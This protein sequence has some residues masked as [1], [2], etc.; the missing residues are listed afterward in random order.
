LLLASAADYTP[1][2]TSPALIQ[3][4]LT[5]PTGKPPVKLTMTFSE[6]VNLGELDVSFIALVDSHGNQY[7]LTS[8]IATQNPFTPT[9]VEL[10]VDA[11]DLAGLRSKES[12]GRTSALTYITIGVG[13]ITDHNS[14]PIVAIV[15][16]SPLP[17]TQHTVDV[18]PPV[19]HKFDLD[20]DANTL[21]VYYTDDSVV[22]LDSVDPSAFTIVDSQN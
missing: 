5:M 12:I 10:T 14:Q 7:P 15:A 2:T 8:G 13:A 1:D 17:V 6:T 4:D 9:I 3:F 18:T 16:S 21:T 22:Q 11:T 20:L 19:V